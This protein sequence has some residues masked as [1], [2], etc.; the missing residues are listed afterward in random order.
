VRRP[1]RNKDLP[2]A[3]RASRMG[4]NVRSGIGLDLYPIKIQYAYRKLILYKIL[5]I[6][7]WFLSSRNVLI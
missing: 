2:P 7:V 5:P 4:Q 6:V 3:G 1:I